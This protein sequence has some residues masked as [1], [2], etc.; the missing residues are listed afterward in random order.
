ME[1][2]Y[3]CRECGRISPARY[4]PDHKPKPRQG[5]RGGSTRQWRKL[6][7]R[8]L[9][10]DGYRCRLGLKGCTLDATHAAHVRARSKGGQDTMANLVASCAHCNLSMG[11]R[12]APV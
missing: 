10:R 12:E 1:K 3:S 8:V 6:R 4:C 9:A 2:H 5:S 11:T 7:A